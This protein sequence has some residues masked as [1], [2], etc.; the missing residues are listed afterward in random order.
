MTICNTKMCN[1]NGNVIASFFQNTTDSDFQDIPPLDKIPT[2]EFIEKFLEDED[3]PGLSAESTL[4]DMSGSRGSKTGPADLSDDDLET[5]LDIKG[6]DDI[7]H[8]R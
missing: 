4:L 1:Y 8:A 7:N 5:V 6:K 2:N 3:H